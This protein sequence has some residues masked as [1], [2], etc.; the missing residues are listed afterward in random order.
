[1][2]LRAVSRLVST[3]FRGNRPDVAMSGDAARKSACATSGRRL[4]LATLERRK[5]AEFFETPVD[6]GASQRAEAL[7]TKLLA[8][9]ATHDRSVDHGP[10]QVAPRDVIGF[11]IEALLRQVPDEPAGETIACAGGIEDVLEQVTRH[12]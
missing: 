6:L 5:F 11:Q 12:N 9:K 3:P 10:A 1:A 4:D 2:L 7:H 8:A